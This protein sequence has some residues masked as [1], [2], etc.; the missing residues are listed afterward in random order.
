MIGNRI[1]AALL[2]SFAFAAETAGAA[3]PDQAG[4]YAGIDLT[5]TSLNMGGSSVDQ[6]FGNQAL[7]TATSI[8]SSDTVGGINVGYRFNPHFAL[9]GGLNSLGK[10]SYTSAVIAP[11]VDTITG[12]YAAHAWS[13]SGLGIAPIGDKFAVYGK[14][15]FAHTVA[16]LAAS[17]T[18]GAVTVGGTSHSDN[19]F[20]LGAGATF[21][22][23]PSV[24]G[25]IGWDRY[26]GVG[27]A[28]ITGRGDIDVYS[29]GIGVRF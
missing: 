24:F 19:G 21:D 20:V 10:Y 11:A 13:F 25:K 23:T 15:G 9:E 7:T 27:D 28:N 2:V 14:L 6:A 16:N 17:S 4:W 8:G 29:L 5:R 22:F 1:R 3:P 18:A 26:T 12:N